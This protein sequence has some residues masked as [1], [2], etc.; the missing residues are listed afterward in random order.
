MTRFACSRAAKPAARAARSGDI[1]E[2]WRTP[3]CVPGRIGGPRCVEPGRALV[4]DRPLKEHVV[5]PNTGDLEIARCEPDP[6]E[7]V[8]FQHAL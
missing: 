4:L 6:D 5:A 3:A 8:L 1:R 7:A 2:L